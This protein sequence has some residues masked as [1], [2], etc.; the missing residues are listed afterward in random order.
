METIIH[1]NKR[2]LLRII[3]LGGQ[4]NPDSCLVFKV[5]LFHMKAKCTR[6]QIILHIIALKKK[7]HLDG[8]V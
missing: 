7:S 6:K 4:F 1:E 8:N 2:M 3:A 5:S